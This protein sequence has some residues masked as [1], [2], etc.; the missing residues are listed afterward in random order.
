[1]ERLRITRGGWV[2][3][4][5]CAAFVA[6][7]AAS[8]M[9]AALHGDG[10]YTYL[11]ARSLAYDLDLDLE[12]DYELCG[13]PWGMS[14]PLSPELTVRNQWNP[15]PALVWAPFLAVVRIV[16][17]A[18]DDPD[19]LVRHA[20]R[21]PLA[22][23]ALWG[24]VAMALAALL[25]IHR[26]ARRHVSESAALFA[27]ACTAF[28]TPLMYYGAYLLSYGHAPSAFAVAL[29][30]ERWDATRERRTWRGWMLLGALLGVAMLMRPQNALIAIA[31]FYEWLDSAGRAL[32][33][34]HRERLL[35]LIGVG[36]LFVLAILVAF[37]PQL[38][39]WTQSYGSPLA[40][41]QGPHYMR[42]DRALP[43]FHAVLFASTGGLLYWT[44]LL[45]VSFAGLIFS[46]RRRSIAR[47]LVI[48]LVAAI[49]VNAAVWDYWGSAGFSN[50]RMTALSAVYGL[51]FAFA[52]ESLFRA[53][54]RHPERVA[55]VLTACV[56][57]VFV[58][59]QFGAAVAVATGKAQ[60]HRE[61]RS[62]EAWQRIFDQ[63]KKV[64]RYIGNPLTYPASLPFA[65]KQG[66]HPRH[67][68]VLY[69]QGVFYAEYQDAQPRRGEDVIQL[70]APRPREYLVSGFSK[71][72]HDIDGRHAMAV[73]GREGRMLLPLFIDSYA[74][75]E[76]EWKS[77]S[78]R[79]ALV[80]VEWGGVALGAQEVPTDW[81]RARFRIPFR[82]VQSGVIDV[83]LVRLDG[84]AVAV[85]KLRI[86]TPAAMESDSD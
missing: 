68:D 34:G 55:G 8:P 13:D 45:Y 42:W 25:L 47:P 79:P 85:S 75:I 52:F 72:A 5:L 40:V 35:R 51:G 58:V 26:M 38:W 23:T 6:T 30:L 17:P 82:H 24:T 14:A 11:W 73:V 32:V 53:A 70:A 36:V 28:A 60:S 20:C 86:L 63:V 67:Y 65:L 61:Q 66:V 62:D 41:P 50:R 22:E 56:L 18:R 1:M 37:S 46:L 74:G 21:G 83:R 71:E 43:N 81:G 27:V 33:L 54:R 19:P 15:G 76:L 12:N 3:A 78:D 31:P 39:I 48:L 80:R 64:Y 16:H 77:L 4:V 10:Y 9:S 44:P 57:S 29:F 59:G 84:G 2:L 69:G 7:A 49:L